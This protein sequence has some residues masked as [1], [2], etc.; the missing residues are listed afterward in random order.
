MF[1]NLLPRVL[2]T[3]LS[4]NSDLD[5]FNDMKNLYGTQGLICGSVANSRGE[6]HS[7]EDSAQGV[8]SSIHSN[9]RTNLQ[10]TE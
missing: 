10:I 3:V 4:Y 9:G 8:A 2:F 1:T 7:D 5:V 6:G